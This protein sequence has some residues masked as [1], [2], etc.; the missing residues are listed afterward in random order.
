[1]KGFFVERPGMLYCW[2]SIKACERSNDVLQYLV[3]QL[4]EHLSL[5]GTIMDVTLRSDQSLVEE[6]EIREVIL[7]FAEAEAE[8]KPQATIHLFEL[9]DG[10]SCEVEV[11][12]EYGA[13]GEA[14]QTERT[15]SFW[16]QARALVPEISLTEKRRYVEPGLSAQAALMLDYHFVVAQPQTE[17]EQ[18]RLT[19]ALERFAADLGKLVRLS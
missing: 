18:Q 11:E 14:E 3:E 9:G 12:V 2:E 7:S 1:V 19:H 4:N 8:G 13:C 6:E 16:E 10:N 15:D 17:A 5:H